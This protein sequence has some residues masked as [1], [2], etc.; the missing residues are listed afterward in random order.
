MLVLILPQLYRV[1]G[2]IS[3]SDIAHPKVGPLPAQQFKPPPRHRCITFRRIARINDDLQHLVN[4]Q[5][6]KIL[7]ELV[8]RSN[9]RVIVDLQ[10]PR[11]EV[12]IDE[13]VI[14]EKLE[15]IFPRTFQKMLLR[16][17]HRVDDHLLHPCSYLIHY[18]VR[19][20]FVFRLQ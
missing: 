12:L 3:T 4:H 19:A 18:Q 7:D 10:D 8:R 2:G 6:Q 17:V 15:L 1:G 5:R 11:S 16:A 14:P 20:V 13:K 9:V